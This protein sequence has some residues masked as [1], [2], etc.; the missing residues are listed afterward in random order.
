MA[1]KPDFGFYGKGLEGYVHYKTATDRA[2]KRSGGGSKGGGSGNNNGGCLSVFAL[3]AI[4]GW[5]FTAL[6]R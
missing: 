5:L 6:F 4:C 1:D 3:F 2:T